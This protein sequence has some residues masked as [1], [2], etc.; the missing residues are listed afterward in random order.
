VSGGAVVVPVR[1][2]PSFRG[3]GIDALLSK[4]VW[5][6]AG[7]LG[8]DWGE[9]GWVLEDNLPMRNALERMGFDRYKTY[10]VY[11]RAL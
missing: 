2:L 10:R 7:R 9:A 3:R 6:G 11:E 4:R 1:R 5:D 8:Y